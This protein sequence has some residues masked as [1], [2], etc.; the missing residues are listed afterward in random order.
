MIANSHYLYSWPLFS[1]ALSCA[2]ALVH[3]IV[4]GRGKGPSQHY[5][6][7]VDWKL[8]ISYCYVLDKYQHK[9]SSKK[10]KCYIKA[11]VNIAAI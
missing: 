2:Q 4:W 10:K 7:V 1:H 6:V 5:T 9:A 3:K 11:G 8:S